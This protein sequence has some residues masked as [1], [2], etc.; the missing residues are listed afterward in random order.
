M[1]HYRVGGNL[2]R[3]LQLCGA[4]FKCYL[5]NAMYLS[6]YLARGGVCARRKAIELIKEGQ[7]LVNGEVQT[8]PAYL[9]QSHDKVIYA[10]CRVKPE[11]PVYV[12]L[13]KPR[14]VV[15]S[16][17]DEQ[18]RKTVVDMITL[19]MN[20]KQVRLYPVG[21]LD[22][23]TTGT[24]ILTNDGDAAQKMAH[25][26]HEVKKTYIA[27]LDAEFT[28]EAYEALK[29]GM[30]L[31]DGRFLPDKVYYPRRHNKFVVGLIIHSGKYRVIRRAF[32]KLGYEVLALDRV[33][34]GSLTTRGLARGAWRLLS[35][36][37]I[38]DF[39]GE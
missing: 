10:E 9:V 32:Y 19:K 30:Y 36:E 26:K 24:L 16:C 21:R 31:H 34:Y 39:T 20:K 3:A 27:Q 5:G 38:T 13:N 25:P 37:E 1:V 11:P 18:R 15:S 6:V 14:G 7:V 35:S 2:S 4:R 23:E 28:H 12:L 33:A 22:K 29:K 8:N 17:A